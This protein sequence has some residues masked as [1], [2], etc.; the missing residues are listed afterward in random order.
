MSDAFANLQEHRV[1]C[2]GCAHNFVYETEP[3]VCMGAI[4]CPQCAKVLTQETRKPWS[5]VAW[6]GK[7]ISRSPTYDERS[8]AEKWLAAQRRRFHPKHW[9]RS[10]LLKQGLLH[11]INANQ[12]GLKRVSAQ[13][14]V[15]NL[16]G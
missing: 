6:H 5:G 8:E 12:R 4:Q 10:T 13:K 2:P 14:V 9:M 3:E 1:T 16:L 11:H 15:E 7:R